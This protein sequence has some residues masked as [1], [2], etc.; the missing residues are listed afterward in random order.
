LQIIGWEKLCQKYSKI[1]PRTL[2]Q[3]FFVLLYA[4]V[5]N[6]P[7]RKVT[8]EKIKKAQKLYKKTKAGDDPGFA[9]K[10]RKKLT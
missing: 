6:I 8:K 7:L 9:K 2:T 4:I 1:H 10:S 5:H 3:E